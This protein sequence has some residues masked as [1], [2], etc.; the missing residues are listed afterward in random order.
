[1]PE[2][3]TTRTVKPGG[4]PRKSDGEALSEILKFRT[5]ISERAQIEAAARAAGLSVSAF[6]RQRAL[7]HTP[8]ATSSRTEAA[9]ISELNRLVVEA[10]RV[11]NNVNQLARSVHRDSAFQE[12]WREIAREVDALN[13]QLR[14]ALERLVTK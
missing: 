14:G 8:R 13:G 11:G 5:S 9:T 12:W 4:R 1:M 6:V 10:G 2:Q 3:R 7:G